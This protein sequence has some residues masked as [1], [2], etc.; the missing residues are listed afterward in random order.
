MTYLSM[1]KIPKN[2]QQ[3]QYHLLE[4]KSNYRKVSGYKV[5]IQKSIALLYTCNK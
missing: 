1:L 4:L 5:N 2:Q 3:Q